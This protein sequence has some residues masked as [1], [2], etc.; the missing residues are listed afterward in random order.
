MTEENIL[1]EKIKNLTEDLRHAGERRDWDQC[2]ILELYIE[3]LTANLNLMLRSE[4]F[5]I[6]K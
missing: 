5:S 4:Y 3:E 1:R 2:D 6:E